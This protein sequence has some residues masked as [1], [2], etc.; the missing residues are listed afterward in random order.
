[1]I[2]DLTLSINTMLAYLCLVNV[3]RMACAPYLPKKKRKTRTGAFHYECERRRYNLNN[4]FHFKLLSFCTK[5][6]A[7]IQIFRNRK[8][9]RKQLKMKLFLFNPNEEV[10][11][12]AP[13]MIV[14]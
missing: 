14:C 13:D 2:N 11:Y 3:S 5:Y 7:I 10:T 4:M 12:I 8:I 9:N 6:R 1:M